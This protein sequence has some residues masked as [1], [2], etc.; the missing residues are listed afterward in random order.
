MYLNF[1]TLSKLSITKSGKWSRNDKDYFKTFYVLNLYD[2]NR[3]G[4][5][6]SFLRNFQISTTKTERRITMIIIM[7][8]Y[9]AQHYPLFECATMRFRHSNRKP[10]THPHNV[11]P[12][13]QKTKAQRKPTKAGMESANKNSHTTTGKLQWWKASVWA[14]NQP[15]LAQDKQKQ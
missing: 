15:A 8:S 11:V 2:Q 1:Q 12:E 9:N 6:N 14:L 13:Y 10:Q 3:L 5:I 4:R 7:L